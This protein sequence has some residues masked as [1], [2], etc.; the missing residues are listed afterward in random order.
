MQCVGE[1]GIY[2][3]LSEVWD[4]DGNLWGEMKSGIGWV[5]LIEGDLVCRRCGIYFPYKGLYADG[6]CDDCYFG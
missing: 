4:A 1:A 6:L 3:I 5:L 2:T